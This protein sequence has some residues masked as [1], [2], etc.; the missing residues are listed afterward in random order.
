LESFEYV[1]AHCHVDLYPDYNAIVAEAESRST[2]ILAVTTTPRAFHGNVARANGSPAVIVGLGLHPQVVG[3]S[4]DDLRLFDSLIDD[5]TAI[6]EVGLD[7]S[8]KYY[9]TFSEQKR[10]FA[11]IIAAAAGVGGRPVSIHAVRAVTQVMKIIERND[12][13]RLNR[14]GIHWFS[15]TLSELRAAIDEG[16]YFSVNS[17]MWRGRNAIELLQALPRD[18]VFT[19]TD[20]P[21][22]EEA[23]ATLRPPDVRSVIDALTKVW[24]VSH[25]EARRR[26]VATF[27][28]FMADKM[29][30]M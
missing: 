27:A 2:R 8:P 7:A 21:F 5:A 10:I 11:H 4:H 19:E 26:V 30:A 14:Y 1:D 3:T 24:V 9:G 17:A 18:R 25:A 12:P 13:K 22:I 15:G 16:Y 6:G 23:G 28:R 20:G 29:L